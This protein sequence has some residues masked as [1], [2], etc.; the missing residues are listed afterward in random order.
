MT[1]GPERPVGLGHRATA[2]SSITW[3]SGILHPHLARR[4]AGLEHWRSCARRRSTARLV[5]VDAERDV[6]RRRVERRGGGSP[7]GRPSTPAMR[8]T[9]A[10]P[11][12]SHAPGNAEVG[13]RDSTRSRARRDRRRASAR[14]RAPGRTRGSCRGRSCVAGDGYA[15]RRTGKRAR[16][17]AAP[18]AGLHPGCRRSVRRWTTRSPAS[19]PRPRPSSA[20]PR[21]EPARAGRGRDRA[22]RAA[23]PAAERG[24]P[25]ALR[26]RARG[27]EGDRAGQRALRRR[28]LPGE[29][30]PLHRR[31]AIRSTSGT[32]VLRDAGLRA[33]HDS[34]LA[35]KLKAA[36]LVILGRTNTPELGTL[37][38]T[39]PDAYGPTRNPWNL[40]HSTGGSSGGSAA[41]VAAGLV[42]GGARQRRRRLDPH[43]GERV[44][45]GRAQ[46]VARAHVVRS[47]AWAT[48]VGGLGVRGRGDAQRARHGG[49]ARRDRRPHAGRSV[50]GAAAARG[51]GARRWAPRPGGCAS[52]SAPRPP[53][54]MGVVHPEAVA[55]GRAH[56]G[57]CWRRSATTSTTHRRTRSTTPRSRATSPCMYATN[58]AFMLDM[59]GDDRRA[60]RSPPTTSIRSTGRSPR[61]AARAPAPQLLEAMSWL[62]GYT[63]ARRGVVGE[64]LRPPAHPHP[65][66]AAA[67]ARH[68]SG[69][70]RARPDGRG[71]ARRPRSRPSPC[72]STPR[73]QPAISLPLHWTRRRPAGRRAA[74]RAVR[75]RGRADPRRRAARGGAARGPT[76]VPP[77]HA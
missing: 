4:R 54:G 14:D 41:A 20:A 6:L 64:R 61:S 53:G 63:P 27:G 75:R 59:L 37:P 12:R 8:C 49:A 65:A 76:V 57:S 28:A 66:R 7:S 51:P 2:I 1:C 30:L 15:H 40:G 24:D 42:R 47:R 21:G 56:G 22:H 16:R 34:Y 48:A 29:G 39:E 45:A 69:P 23:Q 26:R 43:P 60:A 71:P 74:R 3:P 52:A 10:S 73:G 55:R 67:A 9:S 50:L 70:T 33:P 25:P 17:T 35:Q 13:P 38:T 32:R 68:T 62:H 36:G 58:A 77:L 11:A 46:A 5:V 19:T 31:R 18:H 44:R 72:P